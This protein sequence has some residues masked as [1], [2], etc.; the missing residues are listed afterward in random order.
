MNEIGLF[1]APILVSLSSIQDKFWFGYIDFRRN[2]NGDIA[3]I[4]PR[5]AARDNV[6]L[7]HGSHFTRQNDPQCFIAQSSSK[8]LS[9]RRT[10]GT[11]AGT[12][13]EE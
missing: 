1:I 12:F 7:L 5:G 3:T 9:L 4:R 8:L 11:E 6:A 10:L 13:R 2:I